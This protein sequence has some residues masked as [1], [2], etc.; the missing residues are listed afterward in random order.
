MDYSLCFYVPTPFLPLTDW[1]GFMLELILFLMGLTI[2]SSSFRY[3]F[4]QPKLVFF[5]VAFKWTVTVL[6]S[7]GYGFYCLSQSP[8]LLTKV[9]CFERTQTQKTRP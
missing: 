5:G 1:T 9:K 4:K 8:D 6:I 2:P 7:V 3:V